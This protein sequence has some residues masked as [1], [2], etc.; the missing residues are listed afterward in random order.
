MYTDTAGQTGYFQLAY[1]SGDNSSA[2]GTSIAIGGEVTVGVQV[3]TYKDTGWVGI[4]TPYTIRDNFAPL[5]QI[6]T[7]PS[8]LTTYIRN[9]NMYVRWVSP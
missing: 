2:P 3:M 6:R 1:Q 9:V 8:N 4:P 5:G 7:S